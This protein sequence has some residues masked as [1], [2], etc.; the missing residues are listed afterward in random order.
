MVNLIYQ[1]QNKWLEALEIAQKNDRI[2]LRNTH[3]NYAKYLESIN[4][5]ESAVKKFIKI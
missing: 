5:I 2:H 1:S 4:A 3:F